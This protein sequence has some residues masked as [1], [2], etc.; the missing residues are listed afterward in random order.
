ML[1]HCR[2]PH[3]ILLGSLTSSLLSIFFQVV[4]DLSCRGGGGWE[5]GG[6]RGGGRGGTL[7]IERLRA[8]N[9]RRVFAVDRSFLQA[10]KTKLFTEVFLVGLCSVFKK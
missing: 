1:P 2:L 6:G 3:S 4:K 8:K 9:G 5:V 10:L 7:S